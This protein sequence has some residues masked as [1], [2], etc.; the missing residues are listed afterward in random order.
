MNRVRIV[1]SS[2]R[3]S[4]VP[5]YSMPRGMLRNCKTARKGRRFSRDTVY[6]EQ[7]TTFDEARRT[8]SARILAICGASARGSLVRSLTL[9]FTPSAR[10]AHLRSAWRAAAGP[11]A[12]VYTA[13][14]DFSSTPHTPKSRTLLS[15]DPRTRI[16]RRGFFRYCIPAAVADHPA[17]AQGFFCGSARTL[18]RDEE[19]E[20]LERERRGPSL[21]L[22]RSS[23]GISVSLLLAVAPFS[24]TEESR[25]F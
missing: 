7:A 21:S 10:T 23:V 14:H 8:T 11:E 13:N 19:G 15:H 25:P 5:L 17:E 24:A 9:R 12:S 20:F 22:A 6:M 18:R 4:I 1:R 3:I 2:P 16:R